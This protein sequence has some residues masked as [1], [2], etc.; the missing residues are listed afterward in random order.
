[1]AHCARLRALRCVRLDPRGAR[2]AG[3]LA[4]LLLADH[5]LIKGAARAGRVD[6][7]G[8]A[9]I[10][11]A[12]EVLQKA[13]RLR[14]HA[15]ARVGRAVGILLANLGAHFQVDRLGNNLG[16]DLVVLAGLLVRIAVC[17]HG[18]RWID[19]RWKRQKLM[20][21]DDERPVDTHSGSPDWT[22]P[23]GWKWGQ[24][25]SSPTGATSRTT[26]RRSSGRRGCEAF[27]LKRD[28]LL[29]R[30]EATAGLSGKSRASR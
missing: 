6:L 27:F 9:A 3:L 18:K 7:A 17:I 2:T 16:C 4:R 5:V 21:A 24:S 29:I 8:Q 12:V 28:V 23:S 1:M 11:L 15:W 20:K 30:N 14:L 26:T 13:R 22:Q 25:L 10:G 19:K